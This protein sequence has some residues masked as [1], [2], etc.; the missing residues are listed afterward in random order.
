[1]LIGAPAMQIRLDHVSKRFDATTAVDEVSLTVR[2]GEFVTVAGPPGCGKSTLLRLIAGTEVPSSGTVQVESDVA[3]PARFLS[4]AEVTA[5]IG[6]DELAGAAPCVLCDDPLAHVEGPARAGRRD[7]LR[8]LHARLGTTFVFASGDP[9]D[10]LTLSSRIALL[11]RGRLL[12]FAPPTDLLEAPATEFVARFFGRPPINLV[13]AILEKDGQAILVGN[14]TVSLAGRVDEVFCRDITVGIRP[15]H[16]R[17]HAAGVGWRGRVA[18]IEPHSDGVLVDVEVE[19]IRL[20]ALV[21][22]GGDPEV[23]AAVGVRI[24]PK[25]YIVFDDRG[26]HLAQ[27]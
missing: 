19:G 6:G 10:A 24:L 26:V 3:T 2:A 20:R 13:P 1:M 5:A 15:A 23:G 21:G 16:I 12:Q 11:H 27:V 7:A 9:D 4:A 8:A 22:A 17:L 14:Q 25:H 18:A